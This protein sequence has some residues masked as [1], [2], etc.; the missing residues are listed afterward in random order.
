MIRVEAINDTIVWSSETVVNGMEQYNGALKT[1]AREEG[2]LLID[3]E[4]E[5]PKS[6]LWFRDEVHYQD[7]TFSVIAPFVAKH[8]AEHLSHR[9]TAAR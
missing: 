8:L 7:T 6:L 2:L 1:I 3:L 4:Q 5:I 9:Q